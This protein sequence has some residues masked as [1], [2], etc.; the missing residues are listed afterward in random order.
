MSVRRTLVLA[1]VSLV[2]LAL[3]PIAHA[4]PAGQLY[5]SGYNSYGQ[6]G[7]GSTEER[8]TPLLV[9]GLGPVTGASG[10][11]YQTLA[12]L[13]NGTVAA[14]GYNGYGELGDGTKEEHESPETVPG[15]TGV[16]S[17]AA[18]DEFSLA[19]RSDGTVATWGTGGYGELG[20][21]ST[22]KESLTPATVPN[23]SGIV[24]IAAGFDFALALR[25]DGKVE[26]WGYNH[27]DELGDGTKETRYSPEIVPGL[28]NVVAIAASGYAG[29]ALLADGTVEVWGYGG[30]G[31]LGLGSG[32]TA[33]VSSPEV[34]P[35]L[36]NVRTIAAGGYFMLAL[37]DNGTVEGT[38]YNAYYELGD[39]TIEQRDA[40]VP[41]LSNVAS[42]GTDAY[43]SFAV[44][45]NGT[46]EG[47]GYNEDGELGDGS[48]EE[49]H[50]PE[51]L[52]GLTGVF[53]FGRGNYNY[54]M[55]AIEGAFA[56]LSG[57]S[58]AFP[59]E[60]VGAKSSAQSVTLT[61]N[62]PAPLAVSGDVLTGSGAG[63]FAK[64]AD[65]CQGAT[66]NVGQTC[67][68]A[69]VFTPVG[70]GSAEA[71]LAIASSAANTPPVVSLSGTGIAPTPPPPPKPVAP[72]LGALS[73]SSSA[74]RAAAGTILSYTDSEAATTTFTVQR[75][76]AGVTKGSG[77]H[78]SCVARPKHA[79]KGA[80]R[81]TL[82]KRIGS[83]THADA[84]G[85][86]KFRF[87]GR[88]G[89]HTL[90]P[91]SYRLVAVSLSAGGKSSAKTVA[92]KI[93]H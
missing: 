8:H 78:K 49:R 90:K 15:L 91:G 41:V 72:A 36:S 51:V 1:A 85:A 18:G 88:I 50:S 55:L 43:A 58:L 87:I 26:A 52:S 57:S 22:V 40:P 79:K 5:V 64:T 59:A 31:E 66:L 38:G 28:S 81:C 56:G 14:W 6:L 9:S 39:G 89:G 73:L 76:L 19:L 93:K 37:L 47:W 11:Y 44:L 65:T 74:F 33:E 17:V 61:N 2:S 69:L 10:S 75:V 13:A 68:I 32:K 35:A 21:G 25:S 7:I 77:K 29:Y 20:L 80:K 63:A 27:Y 70:A 23:L 86:N 71:S 84:A 60:T 30:Y 16:T 46:V 82:Y 12:T 83:F 67:S 34:V 54:D 53:A 3:A 62:G 24:S 42:I 48:K 45:T 92:F 4:V